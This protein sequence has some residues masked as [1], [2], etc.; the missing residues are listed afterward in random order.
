MQDVELDLLV[1]ILY[2]NNYKNIVGVDFSQEM[3]D[4]ALKKNVYQ[5]LSLCDLT[6]K[7]NFEDDTF[8][9]VICAGTFTCGHVG[10]EALYEMVRIAKSGGLYMLYCSKTR[11]G[12]IPL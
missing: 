11:V 5:S 2:K 10:P 8:D 9:A 3:L 12:G 1:D 4:R 7:L 6:Q